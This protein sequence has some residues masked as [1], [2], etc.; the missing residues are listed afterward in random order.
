MNPMRFKIRPA[1]GG[2][3]VLYQS[4]R[5][6]KIVLWSEVYPDLRD[7]KYAVELTKLYAATAPVV[8]E[9]SRAA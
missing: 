8:V 1:S 4:A 2:W 6:G 3:R 7:A 5:N 9:R